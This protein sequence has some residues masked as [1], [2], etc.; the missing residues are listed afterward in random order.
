MSAL[1]NQLKH[2][3]VLIFSGAMVLVSLFLLTGSVA[4]VSGAGRYQL[5]S[6][7]HSNNN[8]TGQYGAF[9][10]DTITGE[11]QIV[12]LAQINNKTQRVIKNSLKKQFN[13]YD[14][15]MAEY[16]HSIKESSKLDQKS[17]TGQPR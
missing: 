4:V 10:I 15:K 12:Y 2:K 13:Y 5:D 1:K 17:Q 3:A 16:G 8:G 14:S 6:W 11:T 7:S 9:V